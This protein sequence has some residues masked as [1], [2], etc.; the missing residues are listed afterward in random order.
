MMTNNYKIKKVNIFAV[1]I[2][3]LLFLDDGGKLWAGNKKPESTL[4]F[5]QYSLRSL[6]ES[7]HELAAKN[8]LLALQNQQIREKI[9]ELKEELEALQ[10]EKDDL[11]QEAHRQEGQKS[12][13]KNKEDLTKEM[14]DVYAR[15][16]KLGE[17]NKKLNGKMNFYKK[18][19]DHLQKKISS[20]QLEI[21]ELNSKI[22]ILKQQASFSYF[23]QEK[24]K[25]QDILARSSSDLQK[26][27]KQYSQLKAKYG[28]PQKQLVHLERRYADL[29]E[30]LG[31][32]ESQLANVQKDYEGLMND[33][34]LLQDNQKSKLQEMKEDIV[35]LK[36]RKGQLE[37]TLAQ[38]D[39]RLK[40]NKFDLDSYKKEEGDLEQNLAVIKEE[41]VN[42]KEQYS[43]LEE[44]LKTL[45]SDGDGAVK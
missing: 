43:L 44:K 9:K 20:V 4:E 32:M 12:H 26:T 13:L 22:S 2:F 1:L 25:W 40:G 23:E 6:G 17:E 5:Y 31:L 29:K 37:G 18:I 24:N 34:K 39:T 27:D 30:N 10:G 11:R 3:I 7:V 8:D 36:I 16:E 41:N 35:Q 38:A 28:V 14:R 19:R 45:A 15:L 33:L 21:V 42:L